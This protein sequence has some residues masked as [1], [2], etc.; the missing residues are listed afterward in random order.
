MAAATTNIPTTTKQR[1]VRNLAVKAATR[2]FQGTLAALTTAGYLRPAV[3]ANTTDK[4]VGLA[5]GEADNRDGANGDLKL[6]ALIGTFEV[7]YSGTAPT[8]ADLGKPLYVVDDQTVTLDPTGSPPIAGIL[9]DVSVTSSLCWLATG[10][11]VPA[12]I[13]VT[14]TSTNGTAAAASASLANLAAEAEKI[15]DDTRAI[16]AALVKVGILSA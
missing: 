9:H 15:G 8:I 2:I 5:A 11:V 14:L 12:P 16:H 6:D 13:A 3:A 7:A 4:I 1:S 10:E